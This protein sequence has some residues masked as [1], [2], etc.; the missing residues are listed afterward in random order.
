MTFRFLRAVFL[1]AVILFVIFNLGFAFLPTKEGPRFS[2]YQGIVPGR[3]R[4]PFGETPQRSY[5]LSLYDLDA[6]MSSLRLAGPIK[7]A[8]EFRVL[9]IGDSATWGTLL[10][11]EETLAGQLDQMGLKT[12]AGQRMRFYNLGYPTMSLAK[13]L[14][15][16]DAAMVYDPDLVLWLVTLES[17]PVDKQFESPLVQHNPTRVKRLVAAYDFPLAPPDSTLFWQRTWVGQR[18]ALADRLR[19]QLYGVMWAAT[20][21]DQDYPE[22][23]AAA[24]RDLDADVK[25]HQWAGPELLEAEMFYAAFAAG[26]QIAGDVPLLVINEPMLISDGK[27]SDIRYNFYYPRWAY[28][29]YRQEM[30]R[31]LR[32]VGLPYLDA[33]DVVP[34]TQFTNSAVHLS[35]MGVAQF[36]AVVEDWLM[37]WMVGR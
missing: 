11:P 19:L 20:G 33:W 35:P 37:D 5:N 16:L 31:R 24:A 25:F 30:E 26:K 4:L 27:N 2:L 32:A 21:I 8:D 1:K 17:L 29:A 6:M 36:S 13:D 12:P 9:L 3:E 23:Y 10:R 18:R 7:P 34:Q 14:M 22:Q 28:D 15:I